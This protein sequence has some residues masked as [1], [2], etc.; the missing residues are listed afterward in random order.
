MKIYKDNT[1]RNKKFETLVSLDKDNLK[2]FLAKKLRDKMM[3][4]KNEDNMILSDDGFLYYR[5]TFPV[6]LCAHMDTVHHETPT[7]LVYANGT[8][9]SPQGIG[10]DDRCGCY[11]ILKILEHYDC[12]VLFLEDEEDGCIGAKKF[13]RTELCRSI[14]KEGKLKYIIEFDR[15]GNNHAVFY[16]CDNKEFTKF[17][18]QGYFKKEHG[19]CSDISY[20]APSLGCA[21]VNLS[22]GYYH[23]HH[24]DHYVVLE[25]MEMTIKEASKLLAQTDKVERFKYEKSYY[26]SYGSSYRNY[27]YNGYYSKWSEW[28]DDYGYY[29]PRKK[30]QYFFKFIITEEGKQYIKEVFIR[31]DEVEECFYNFFREYPSVCYNDVLCSGWFDEFKNENDL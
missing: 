1:K 6:L 18:T 14:E 7:T 2:V 25:E 30:K 29:Y 20:I 31:G 17:V 23:E 9:S 4:A 11:M 15:K 3:K 26:S 8:I 12:S 28:D 10:G 27:G 5:G 21:A 22:C 19:T 16:N 24:I 13:T